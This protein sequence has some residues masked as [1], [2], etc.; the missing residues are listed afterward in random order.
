[1]PAPP[2]NGKSRRPSVF[3]WNSGNFA[4]GHTGRA[5]ANAGERW[6]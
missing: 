1:M 6:L 2:A 5:A 3:L 4:A